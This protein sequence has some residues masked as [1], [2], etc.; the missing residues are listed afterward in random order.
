MVFDAAGREVARRQLEHRQ[1]L[2]QPGWVE[3]DPIEIAARV[4][5][6]IAGALRAADL[7]GRDLAAIGVTNQ[8][9]TTVVWNPRDGRPWYNAIVWQDTRTDQAVAA[10]EPARALLCER[11]GLPPVDLLLRDEAAVDPRPRRWR[12][13][14]GR[15]RRGALRHGRHLDHLEPDGRRRRR[16]ARDGRDQRQ[17]DAAHGPAHARLGRRA[18]RALPHT[19]ADAAAYLSVVRSVRVRRHASHRTGRR[20]DSDRRRSR[21]ST[22]SARRSGV[23]CARR[24]QE[25]VRDRQL[26]ADEYRARKSCRPRP[27][28][29]RRSRTASR[30]PRPCTR[31]KGRSR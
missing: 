19:A 16:P 8:R 1:I 21:R 13:R 9:E 28:C 23:L 14:G 6:V 10:L 24:S 4:N 3:H 12:A 7:T 2:P 18:A 15:T 11:T 29:S 25:H 31:S 5:E 30:M 27:D 26:H 17:P 20:G 22:R